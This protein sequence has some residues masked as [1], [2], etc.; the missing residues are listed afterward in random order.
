MKRDLLAGLAL[1]LF[2][3]AT[4]PAQA[5]APATVPAGFDAARLRRIDTWMQGYV[6][7]NQIG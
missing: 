3:P 6:D 7:S 1:A 5:R 4:L 2:A